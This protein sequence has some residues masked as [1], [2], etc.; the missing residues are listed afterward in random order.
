[1]VGA[2]MAGGWGKGK[3]LGGLAEEYLAGKEDTPDGPHP[4]SPDLNVAAR[5]IFPPIMP[6]RPH[7]CK[8]WKCGKFVFPERWFVVG[9][10]SLGGTC[11]CPVDESS[12]YKR[13]GA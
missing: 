2:D 13:E 6:K 11:R 4:V 1:M 7:P 8:P 5:A 10:G 12:L 9:Q 3:G